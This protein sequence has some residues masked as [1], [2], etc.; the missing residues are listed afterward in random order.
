MASTADLGGAPGGSTPLGVV[1]GDEEHEL[2][3]TF[4][5]EGEEAVL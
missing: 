1:R 2:V 3:V 5:P 4:G